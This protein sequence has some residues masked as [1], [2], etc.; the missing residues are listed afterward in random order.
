MSMIISLISID[1]NLTTVLLALIALIGTSLITP[2]VTYILKSRQDKA[3]AEAAREAAVAVAVKVEEVKEAAV[4]AASVVAL[5]VEEVKVTANDVAV[6]VEQTRQDLRETSVTA[7]K[8]LDVIHN[9]VNSQLTQAIE[10]FADAVKEVATLKRLLS[11]KAPNDPRVKEAM[12]EAEGEVIAHI[13]EP[14]K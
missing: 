4:S 14:P 3:I 11:E 12:E 8:K 6:K 2:I 1:P 5:K 7:D 9:L 13:V 10:R